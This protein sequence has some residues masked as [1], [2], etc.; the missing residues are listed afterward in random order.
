[1]KLY[2]QEYLTA[3]GNL[4]KVYTDAIRAQAVERVMAAFPEAE[5]T[6]KGN[7]AFVKGQLPDGRNV[8]V[9]LDVTVGYADP[10]VEKAPKAKAPVEVLPI[11]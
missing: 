4:Q 7:L 3:N 6:V 5:V 1:M 10:F 2:T 9:T 8:F 11:D